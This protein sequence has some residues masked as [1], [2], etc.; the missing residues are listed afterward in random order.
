M[1][2]LLLTPSFI[3]TLLSKIP[4]LVTA[5]KKNAAAKKQEKVFLSFFSFSFCTCAEVGERLPVHDLSSSRLT[6]RRKVPPHWGGRLDRIAFLSCDRSTPHVS[7]R[8]TRH[9][10]R[11]GKMRRRGGRGERREEEATRAPP[12]P[13]LPLSACLSPRIKIDIGRPSR[14]LFPANLHC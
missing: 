1:A 14:C 13:P 5:D 3:P 7:Q 2:S 8:R 6:A 10:G 9:I 4:L 12:P 11:V